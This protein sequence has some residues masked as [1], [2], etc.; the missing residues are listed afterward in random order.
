MSNS[1][2]SI[3][4]PVNSSTSAS[5]GTAVYER[6]GVFPFLQLPAELRELVYLYAIQ[7]IT[8]ID[9]AAI[10]GTPDR[11]RIPPVAQV[12]R[13]LREEA[14]HVLFK[15]RPAEISL[16]S[17]E[18]LRRALLWADGWAG[19]SHSFGLIILSGRL[20]SSR[21]DFYHLTLECSE[22]PPYFSVRTRPGASLKAELLI[23]Q[24][25]RRLLDWLNQK[26]KSADN[27]QESRFSKAAIIEMIHIVNNASRLPQLDET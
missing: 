26:V 15:R 12:S 16:H 19:H 9:T 20:E 13:L 18:N 21:N 22:D 27:G 7:P 1:T 4:G 5:S 11:I 3:T 24:I 10:P 23:D 14:L 17:G 8:P 2:H 25:R 6:K